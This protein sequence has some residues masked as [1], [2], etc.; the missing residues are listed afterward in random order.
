KNAAKYSRN[1]YLFLVLAILSGIFN[2]ITYFGSNRSFIVETAITTIAMIIFTFPEYRRRI[3]TVTLPIAA[4][5]IVSMF[6]K[7]QFGV[8][9]TS[10]LSSSTLSAQAISNIIEE[11]VNGLWTVARSY[12]S[13][14][15]LT[16]MQSIHALIKDITNGLL[17]VL[18][19]PGL[20]GILTSTD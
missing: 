10:E 13:S 7:K 8:D 6:V 1:F 11:Y 20:K 3:L 15:N 14:L 12:Q 16:S 2:F 5:I 19:I 18:D 9:S 17:V 4:V